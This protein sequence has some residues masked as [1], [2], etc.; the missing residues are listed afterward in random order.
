[1]DHE[2]AF[3]KS[4]IL[5]AKRARFLQGLA[6]PKT[7]KEALERLSCELPYMTGFAMEV[8]GHQDFPNE[9]EKLLRAKGAGPRC[10]VIADG[11]KAD[12]RELALREA[13]NLVCLH[14]R[15]AV[16]LCLP[17]HLAYYKPES[18]RPGIILERP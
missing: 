1:M 10:H 18:P 8:P 16:L 6:D 2:T 3:T 11:L 12:G 17:G 4:F 5:S 14:D 7:R 15:G 9:L 13:L